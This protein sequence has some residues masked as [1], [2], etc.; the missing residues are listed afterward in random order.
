MIAV[1][2]RSSGNADSQER[3]Q[4]ADSFELVPSTGRITA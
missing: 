3:S 4:L 1:M 2:E